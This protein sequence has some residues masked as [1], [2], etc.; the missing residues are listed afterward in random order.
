[1]V[2]VIKVTFWSSYIS[3]QKLPHHTVKSSQPHTTQNMAN[4]ENVVR[5]FQII[6]KSYN[7]RQNELRRFAQN[8]AF[9]NVLLTSKGGNIAFL[10]HPLR[11][12]LCPC[13]SY[14]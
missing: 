9:F 14:L 10:P 1:M 3:Y 7:R 5:Y 6:V 8:W 2:V 12:M 13:S 4:L 11:A